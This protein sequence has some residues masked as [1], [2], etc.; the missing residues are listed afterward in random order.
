MQISTNKESLYI[1]QVIGEKSDTIIVEEDFVVPDIKPDILNTVNTSGTIC[2][3]KKEVT[4]GKV[5]ID[6]AIDTYIMYMAD[7]VEASTRGLNTKVEFSKTIDFASVKDK[8][9]IDVKLNLKNIECKVLNGRK[10][11]IRG[12][13]DVDLKVMSNEETEFINEVEDCKEVQ[14]LN[15]SIELNSL[16]GRGE[17]KVYA[18]DTLVIDN[19]DNLS[20]ILNVKIKIINKELKISYNKIL[21][22]ADACVKIMY[23]TE[24]NRICK[25]SQIIPVMGFVDMQDIS[26]EDVCDVEFEVKNIV[27][28]PNSIDE[29]SIYVEIELE[30]NCMSYKTKSVNLIQDLYSPKVNLNYNQKQIKAITE[31]KKIKDLYS[32]REE[33][34]IDEIGDSKLYDVEVNPIITKKTNLKDRVMVEG[35]TEIKF[36]FENQN[37]NLDLKIITLPFNYNIDIPGITK[38]S[39]VDVS[40]N[41]LLED[42]TTMP[43]KQIDIKIDLEFEV[44]LNNARF[45]NVI[46]DIVEEEI[47][48]CDKHS[49]V[50]YF[51]KPGD[52]LWKIAKRFH[53]TIQSIAAINEIEDENK[54]SVGE[55]LFIPICI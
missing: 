43:D 8:M 3:Y 12:I 20:E 33:R 11:N 48:D 27:I 10:V 9:M 18:K 38:N 13:I 1:N 19:I 4:E 21:I 37:R 22:K 5:R 46:D 28:K 2:I 51:V 49:L 35:E 34:L 45:I 14:L 36:I 53:S 42:F 41:V 29:H 32:I 24:D 44:S 39:E 23:L 16:L 40:V 52:T 47:K 55:Q 30:I 25:T 26:D 7:D 17:T 15:E 54:I 31:K 6:G 50:V